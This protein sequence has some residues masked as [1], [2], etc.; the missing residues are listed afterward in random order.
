MSDKV[1]EHIE[2]KGLELSPKNTD[3]G[4]GGLLKEPMVWMKDIPGISMNELLN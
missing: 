2:V 4:P 1:L 3:H